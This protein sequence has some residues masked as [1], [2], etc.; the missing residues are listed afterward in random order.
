MRIQLLSDLHLEFHS[1][2]GLAW[3]DALDL[4][5]ADVLVLAGDIAEVRGGLLRRALNAVAMRVRHVVFVPGNHEYYGSSI[6]EVESE[7][8][9]LNAEVAN[10]HVLRA[11]SVTIEGQRFVG[12]T[13]WF[14]RRHDDD[15]AIWMQRLNDFRQIAGGFETWVEETAQRDAAY[16]AAT[17]RPGDIVVTH[18][19]PS[20]RGVAPRWQSSI[21]G[22]GRFFV[23]EL[24]EALVRRA[25]LWCCGHGHDTVRSTMGG[26]TLATNP[27]GYLDLEVNPDFE[28]QCVFVIEE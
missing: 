5:C 10:L 8:D 23:H 11:S 17:V 25:R 18:H 16:L 28:P 9:A 3:L 15:H 6:E 4:S 12:A 19:I 7:L 27:F 14:T 26:H 13:L 20:R 2:G 22:F 24:P 21:D 1:D